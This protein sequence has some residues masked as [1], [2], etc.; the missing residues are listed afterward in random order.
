MKGINR[1]GGGAWTL[2]MRVNGSQGTFRYNST[3][4]SKTATVTKRRR[5]I[6]P[7]YWLSPFNKIGI[8]LRFNAAS[9]TLVLNH[10]APSLH[11]VLQQGNNQAITQDFFL[12]T[13]F[14]WIP[15][16]LDDSCLEKGLNVIASHNMT[17]VKA[18]IGVSS[19]ESRCPYPSPFFARGVGFGLSMGFP[20]NI[21][22]GD[23]YLGDDNDG[24]RVTPAFCE[25]YIQ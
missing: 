15:T 16:T 23:I 25:I 24:P 17:I 21:T 10:T 8:H 11:S 3:A 12:E 9:T 14:P 19:N 7:G 2:V 22:C 4:W 1:C 5:T 18:R 20:D 6:L 13:G